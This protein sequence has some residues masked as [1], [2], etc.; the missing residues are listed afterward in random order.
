MECM[1][2]PLMR[3]AGRASGRQSQV[4]YWRHVFWRNAPMN[5]D[6]RNFRRRALHLLEQLP[7]AGQHSHRTRRTA[8]R[9]A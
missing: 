7:R 1:L 6:T 9:W 4:V 5:N 3:H 8:P 2:P